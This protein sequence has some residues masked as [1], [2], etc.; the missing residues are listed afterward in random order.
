[1]T[2]TRRSIAHLPTLFPAPGV[3]AS[4]QRAAAA[5]GDPAGRRRGTAHLGTEGERHS[6]VGLLEADV[7]MVGDEAAEV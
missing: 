6:P 1:M 4:L 7:P 5:A 3:A 2:T